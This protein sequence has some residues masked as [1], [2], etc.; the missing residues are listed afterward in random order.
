MATALV[1]AALWSGAPLR[2]QLPLPASTIFEMTGFVQQATLD[3]PSDPFSGGTLTVNNHLIVVPRYTIFQMPATSLTW[4]ELFT[5]APGPWGPTQTGLALSDVP[6]PA[7]TFEVTV[8]GNRVMEQDTDRYIA[9]LLF[10]SNLS[11]QAHQ[12]F[13]SAIDYDAG[14]FVVGGSRVRLNDPI[15]RFGRVMTHDK[16][17]TIDEDNPTVKSETGYPMCL[18]RTRVDQGVDDPLCPQGNRPAGKTIFTM[19]T[20]AAPTAAERQNPALRTAVLDP[21]RAAPFQVGDYVTVRG[22]IVKDAAGQYISAYAVDA[23]VGIFTQPGTQPSYVSVDVVLMG[24]GPV[25]DPTLAQEGARRTRVEGFSTDFTTPVVISA[26]DVDACTGDGI[27]RWWATQAI[28]PGPPTG[29]VAGRWR[30]IPAAPLF[31]LKGFPFLPPTREVHV[32]SATG[33]VVTMNGLNA[34]EYVSPNQEFILPENRGVGSP[35]VPGNFETMAFLTQGSGPRNGAYSGQLSPWPGTNPPVRNA[36][37]VVAADPIVTSGSLVTLDGSKS[38]AANVPSGAATYKWTQVSGAPVTLAN[39]TA[40]KTTFTAP[41][42][43]IGGSNLAL[44]FKL[45]AT[46]SNGAPAVDSRF[47]TVTVTPPPD[48]TAPIVAAPSAVQGTSTN[49]KRGVVTT[50]S[51]AASDNVAVTSVTFTYSYTVNGVK[52]S[53]SVPATKGSGTTWS[54]T[55]TPLSSVPS[56]T[57]YTFTALARDAAGNSTTSSA[58]TKAIQ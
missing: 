37:A 51:A 23:N 9:G 6:K 7:F 58:T 39:A 40:A 29:A 38:V 15:G 1:V 27:D 5:Q 19:L 56:G 4:T 48:T 28:D 10:V 41:T 30:F 43:A 47:V 11:V 33:T 2:A 57:S 44:V 18:P 22:P 20:P 35:I 36:C 50:L 31:D 55:F 25:N 49:L 53:G 8:Q 13:I 24:T 12:G 52:N 26:L 14:E 17:F 42:V 45:T 46:P 54:G 32:V 3:N 21:W 34:G 16:R